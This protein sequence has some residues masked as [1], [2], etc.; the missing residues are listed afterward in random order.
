MMADRSENFKV[1]HL[2]MLRGHSICRDNS[3]RPWYAG[4]MIRRSAAIL[5]AILTGCSHPEP[6]PGCLSRE[7]LESLPHVA[8][9]EITPATGNQ[10]R[11]VIHL[12]NWHFVERPA[13]VADIQA[14]AGKPLTDAEIEREWTAFC[15]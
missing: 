14:T 10:T 15:R 9:V 2:H 7:T 4:T 3:S 12:L 5:I 1:F 6:P 8:T 11:P 13:F